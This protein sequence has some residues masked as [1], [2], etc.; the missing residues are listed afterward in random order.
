[1]RWSRLPQEWRGRRA[2]RG[3]E[4][5]QGDRGRCDPAEQR[6]EGEDEHAYKEDPVAAEVVAELGDGWLQRHLPGRAYL[7]A[8]QALLLIAIVCAVLLFLVFPWVEP[9]LWFTHVTVG[10]G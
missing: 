9:K 3:A 5:D 8:A 1:M 6:A 7:R 10:N 4:C 2:L